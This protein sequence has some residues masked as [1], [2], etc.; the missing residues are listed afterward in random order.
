LQSV[1]AVSK[2][3]EFNGLDRICTRQIIKRRIRLHEP[4]L[5][6]L[7]ICIVLV[8]AGIFLGFCTPLCVPK[9][10]DRRQ[11]KR[12]ALNTQSGQGHGVSFQADA[13][14]SGRRFFSTST[15]HVCRG[16]TKKQSTQNTQFADV[17]FLF[18]LPDV[19]MQLFVFV[20]A[21]RLPILFL[22][23]CALESAD[24]V[25]VFKNPFLTVGYVFRGV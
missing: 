13:V 22:L 1:V 8:V 18:L 6:A 25:P 14:S 5:K 12:K 15:T 11:C 19:V 21:L 17:L 16:T 20:L 4:A 7:T 2:N 9:L 24:R 10:R 23:L 3:R